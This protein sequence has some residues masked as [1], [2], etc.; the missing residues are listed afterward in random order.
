MS[1]KE[2]ITI[3]FTDPDDLKL[4]EVIQGIPKGA[5]GIVVRDILRAGLLGSEPTAGMIPVKQPQPQEPPQPEQAP[6]I[7]V[8]LDMLGNMP[9]FGKKAVKHD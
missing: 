1:R 4:Y 2:K 8:N 5:R 6:V 9:V 7:E 3:Y